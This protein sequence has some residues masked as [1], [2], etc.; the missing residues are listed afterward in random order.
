LGVDARG[1][2]LREL[3]AAD[4]YEVLDLLQELVSGLDLT[5]HGKRLVYAAVRSFFTHNRVGLPVDRS[6]KIQSD[7]PPLM[8]R[9][10]LEHVADVV[11]GA[12]LRDRSMVLVKWMGLLNNARTVYVRQ[13][14]AEQVV[15]Q[16]RAGVHPNPSRY[17][18]SSSGVGSPVF[19][20]LASGQASQ[21]F[22]FGRHVSHRSNSRC[23]STP[24]DSSHNLSQPER[25]VAP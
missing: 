13:R 11:R 1:L 8:P 23:F 19:L 22:T 6:F 25:S 7:K 15:K 14:L 21:A 5:F 2:L 3:G 10:I 4:P 18:G 16:I 9:L 12:N 17:I 20:S 24:L